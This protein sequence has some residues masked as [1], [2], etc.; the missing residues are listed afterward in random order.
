MAKRENFDLKEALSQMEIEKKQL[1][2][3]IVTQKYYNTRA[4]SRT[5]STNSATGSGHMA[6]HGGRQP[7]SGLA[8]Q[9]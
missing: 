8:T 2:D 4:H 6:Y 7:H 5:N 3:Q 1:N 9:I